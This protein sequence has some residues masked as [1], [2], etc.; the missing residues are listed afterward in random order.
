MALLLL[1]N[2][3]DQI[4]INLPDLKNNTAMDLCILRDNTDM[5]KLLIEIFKDKIDI[6]TLHETNFLYTF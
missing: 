2:F 1:D 5:A 6:N 3:N 4:D